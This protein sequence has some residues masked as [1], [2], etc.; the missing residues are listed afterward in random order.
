MG[1]LFT[2]VSG[3]RVSRV[4]G[5]AGLVGLIGLEMESKILARC[6]RLGRSDNNVIGLC[7]TATI[8]VKHGPSVTRGSLGFT[9]I[10]RGQDFVCGVHFF[11]QKS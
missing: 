1:A 7:R 5:L 2:T 9:C 3:I 6:G 10:R 8:E 11:L 4:V